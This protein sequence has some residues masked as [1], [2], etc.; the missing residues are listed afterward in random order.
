[1]SCVAAAV[2]SAVAAVAGAGISMY[3]GN[4]SAKIAKRS[5]REQAEAAEKELARAEQ[6]F[7][8]VNQNTANVEG[9][10][11]A[12]TAQG[13]GSTSLS[14]GMGSPIDPTKLGGGSGLLGG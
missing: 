3:Q 8:R 7:N 6:D 2:V 13:Q 5:A 12:N 14:G 1:M 11:E 10:L 4:K 9:L